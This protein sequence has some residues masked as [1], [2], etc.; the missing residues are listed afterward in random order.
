MDASTIDAMDLVA[1]EQMLADQ[2]AVPRS[3]IYRQGYGPTP[4]INAVQPIRPQKALER[5]KVSAGQ[6]VQ[7]LRSGTLGR[8]GNNPFCHHRALELARRGQR[9]RL[10]QVERPP[11][12]PFDQGR[13]EIVLEELAGGG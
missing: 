1:F 11:G 12:V 6:L 2:W 9:E 3:D 7:L 10:V 13:F 8:P 5:L 4:L